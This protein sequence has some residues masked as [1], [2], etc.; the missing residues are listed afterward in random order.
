[1]NL[2]SR[3]EVGEE[4]EPLTHFRLFGLRG[5]PG[6]GPRLLAL[7]PPLTLLL[8]RLAPLVRGLREGHFSVLAVMQCIIL[9]QD[10]LSSITQ[11]TNLHC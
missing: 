7:L 8:L 11:I 10:F 2:S 5:R 1:M 9:I 3:V 6:P 4:A